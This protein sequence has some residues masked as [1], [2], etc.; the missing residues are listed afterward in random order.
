MDSGR[1]WEY[2]DA[3]TEKITDGFSV[4]TLP[5]FLWLA[6]YDACGFFIHGDTLPYVSSGAS[7]WS[8]PFRS[9]AGCH[10]EVIILEPEK[11]NDRRR[12][13]KYRETGTENTRELRTRR[14]RIRENA[15]R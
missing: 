9:E 10:Y 7:G 14:G 12:D 4:F 8:F 6:G 2:R 3:P 13:L 1:F 11:Q 5:H 15:Y